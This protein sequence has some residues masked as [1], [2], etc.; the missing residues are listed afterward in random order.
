MR[1]LQAQAR[2][3]DGQA[4]ADCARRWAAAR[5]LISQSGGRFV[6]R[7][8]LATS[9]EFRRDKGPRQKRAGVEDNQIGRAPGAVLSGFGLLVL[10]SAGA[11]VAA[12]ADGSLAGRGLG[13]YGPRR[14]CATWPVPALAAPTVAGGM[15]R[16]G[17]EVAS[18]LAGGQAGW[19][20]SESD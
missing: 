14:D 7:S 5:P 1:L 10:V 11:Q 16:R 20:V 9:K 15:S 18:G 17:G 8:R 13:N 2:R 12:P 19:R 4:A 6:G 3:S